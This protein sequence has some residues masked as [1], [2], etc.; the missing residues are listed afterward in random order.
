MKRLFT[1]LLVLG[2]A[3]SITSVWAQSTLV[4][5]TTDKISDIDPANAYDFHTW[6]IFYNTMDGL[7][8]YAPGG[9]AL[10]PAL[11]TSWSAN[12]AS[13]QF[14]FKLRKGVKFSDGTPFDARVVKWTIDRNA[15]IEGD[16]SWL[17]TDFV[18][19][20]EVV[21]PYT[22]KFI[23]KNP[24]AFFP[25]LLANPPY[26][27]LSPNTFPEG[28][29]GVYVKDPSELKGGVL[30]GLGT[31]TMTSFKRDEEIVL[32]YNPNYWGKA[33][34]Y[35]KVIIRY[36][37][38]ATTMRLALEKGEV[39]LVYKSL[40]PSDINDL[41]KNSKLTVFKNQGPF[42]RYLAFETSESVFK[43]KKLRQAIT[44]LLNRP[45][46]TQKVY[47]GQAIPLYSMVPNG[48][49]YQKT[50]FK[51]AFG[52]G[53]VAKAETILKGLGYTKDKPFTFDLWYSPS[54]YG[55]TEANLA[56]VVKAQIEKTPLVKVTIKSAE[57]A[58]Y[59][60]Q[61]HDKQMAVFFL[62]WYPDY[63]DADNYTAAFAGTSGSIGNGIYFSNP[64]WDAMFTKEQT[65]TKETERKA[66]FEKVQDLWV[67]EVPTAPLFQGYLILVSKKSV[68][69][70]KIGPPMI[71]LYNQLKPVK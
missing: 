40:N 52:D 23:L 59:K 6:E 28:S 30:S 35:K 54:H 49:Q 7:V 29:K 67:D 8:G 16:P 13:D 10:V 51:T 34:A 22:V 19:S 1:L 66:V 50:T 43:D 57:W 3:L 70:V 48:M 24:V 62:G 53:N 37:A 25:K 39:D 5:G 12:A 36:F 11:A 14:T 45:E 31:Y 20:V 56:E 26:Y 58:T 33:P 71:F 18:K 47:L 41:S 69:G 32:D 4:Y 46:I 60:Q 9:S 61:W 21:D 44:S 17:I 55:D 27:P 63:V 42:I 68:T 38:D 15:A 2:L 64:D 65:S